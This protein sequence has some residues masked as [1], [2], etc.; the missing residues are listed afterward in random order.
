MI[1]PSDPPSPPK[2]YGS[3]RPP[4]GWGWVPLPPGWG[5][6]VGVWCGAPCFWM[7]PTHLGGG[8]YIFSGLV[9]FF[10]FRVLFCFFHPFSSCLLLGFSQ[11]SVGFCGFLASLASLASV[12]FGVS[13]FCGF[14]VAVGHLLGC[15]RFFLVR[16]SYIR[17]VTPCCFHFYF[18]TLMTCTDNSTAFALGGGAAPSPQLPPAFFCSLRHGRQTGEKPSSRLSTRREG[19][20]EKQDPK[21]KKKQAPNKSGTLWGGGHAA[22][23][24]DHIYIIEAK[25]IIFP[26]LAC[27]A[28]TDRPHGIVPPGPDPRTR[29]QH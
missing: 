27:S 3:P 14:L 15:G 1:Q 21:K 28:S 8:G 13:G 11:L 19:I 5:V 12:A 29:F 16:I 4:C 7:D 9:F 22:G 20:K 24:R 17:H 23:G 25:V 18:G 26:M 2:G 10:L 6:C